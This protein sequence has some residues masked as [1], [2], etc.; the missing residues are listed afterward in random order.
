MPRPT[1]DLHIDFE[2][3]CD[4]DLKKVG[5]H[6]Y[7]E[8]PS[9]RL[10]CMAWK[11]DG[12]PA[13]SELAWLTMRGL[14]PDLAASTQEPRRAGPRVERRV[15]NRRAEPVGGVRR[16]PAQLH[17]AES[18]GLRPAGEAGGSGSGGGAG[19]PEGHARAPADAEDVATAEAGGTGMDIAG[20]PD[21][22]G[23]LRQGRGGRSRAVGGDP[24]T[25]AGGAR[26][27]RTGRRS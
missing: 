5:I 26:T 16:P 9:F 23:L 8:H 22:D 6:Q 7:V 10:L 19:A 17:H 2:T 14:P 18:L 12:R 15:R 1:L 24:R 21:A 27:V 4:L 11:I 20:L 25:A 13:V 3:Y